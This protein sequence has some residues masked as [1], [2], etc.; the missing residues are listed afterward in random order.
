MGTAFYF[1]RTRQHR[2]KY[3]KDSEWRSF[4]KLVDEFSISRI[5]PRDSKE[6]PFIQLADL[7]AG[8]AAYSYLHYDYYDQWK[9]SNTR[10]MKLFETETCSQ[11]KLSGADKERCRVLDYFNNNNCK[12][13]KLGVSLKSN[14]GLKTPNPKNPINF[15][16]YVPQHETDKAPLK[17]KHE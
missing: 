14:R 16:F 3:E 9:H 11:F 6:E 8:L 10:Q 7:F 5:E 15:W 12:R 4:V 2:R 1:S 17:E 13:Y